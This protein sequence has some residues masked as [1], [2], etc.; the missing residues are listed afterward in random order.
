VTALVVLA[1]GRARRYGGIKPL[2]PVGPNGEAIIDLLAGDAL[3]AGFSRLV[4]VVNPDTGGQIESHVTT[5]W[6]GSVDVAFCVQERPIGTVHAVLVARGEA[7]SGSA[8]GVANADDL[9]GHDALAVL[10][11]H[12]GTSGTNALVGFHLDRALVGDLP[13]TRGV[14]EVSDGVLTAVT[15]RR[16]VTRVGDTFTAGDGLEPEVLEPSS[17]VSMNLW[18]FDPRMW[19]VLATAMAAAH[20]AS[21]EHEVLLPELIGSVVH[22]GGELSRIAV[23]ETTSRCLGVTHPDDLELVRRELRGQIE[24]GERPA[25]AFSD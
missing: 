5:A 13:V 16:N 9:Y 24:R 15:E 12:V 4:L 22:G 2:A 19:D 3:R 7:D 21:E 11:G 1:A 18:G 6:P 10:G 25:E 8:F 17:L 23:L 20:D 14:C